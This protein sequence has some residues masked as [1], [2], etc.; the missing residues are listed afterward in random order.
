MTGMVQTAQTALIEFVSAVPGF[1]MARRWVLEPWGDPGSPFSLMRSLDVE[2]LEF[3]VVPPSVFFPD[4]EPV[5]DD[6]CVEALDI[7][8]AMDVVVMVVLTIGE[9]VE[10]TTANL[11]GPI[12]VNARTNQ[13]MQTILHQPGLSTKTPIGS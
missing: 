7:E 2:S 11:L 1:P 4:Y 5:L 13:A 12:V 10:T 3:L 8:D 9:S 6:A